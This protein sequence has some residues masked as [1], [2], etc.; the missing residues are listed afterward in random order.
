MSIRALDS[1]ANVNH[2]QLLLV[3]GGGTGIVVP[4][5]TFTL[6]LSTKY[7]TPEPELIRQQ[8]HGKAYFSEMKGALMGGEF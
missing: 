1:V 3:A 2:I 6:R 8:R 7:P 5:V 4:C